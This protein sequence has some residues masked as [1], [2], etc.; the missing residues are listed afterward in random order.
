MQPPA[1]QI[2]E[3]PHDEHAR[4]PKADEPGPLLPERARRVA[5]AGC[6]AAARFLLRSSFGH[7]CCRAAMNRSVKNDSLPARFGHALAGIRLI[8]R[9]EK[10]FRTHALCAIA[11]LGVAAGLR[12]GPLWWALIV[13]CIAIVSALEAMNAALEYLADRLH[14][15]RHEDIGCAKDAAAGAVLLASLGPA[16]VGALMV[17]AWWHG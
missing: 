13:L 1:Q 4:G 15:E 16:I 3:A 12:V 14:P 2:T 5:D 6:I 9:R 7:G 11:A 10:S 17:L 8:W